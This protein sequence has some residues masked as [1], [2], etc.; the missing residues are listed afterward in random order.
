MSLKHHPDDESAILHEVQHVIT[1]EDEQHQKVNIKLVCKS[2]HIQEIVEYITNRISD[3]Y[4]LLLKV[5]E[6]TEENLIIKC[7]SIVNHGET[8]CNCP[9]LVLDYNLD[10]NYFELWK[11][12]G[13]SALFRSS[14]KP[15]RKYVHSKVSIMPEISGE[16]LGLSEFPSGQQ[17]TQCNVSKYDYSAVMKRLQ[18]G[19]Y[20]FHLLIKYCG[21]GPLEILNND[22]AMFLQ[23]HIQQQITSGHEKL[24]QSQ[25][26]KLWG[27][28]T[29]GEKTIRELQ[30]NKET[31]NLIFTN[32]KYK[33][34]KLLY[35][36]FKV[37][38]D[39]NGIIISTSFQFFEV[40]TLKLRAFDCTLQQDSTSQAVSDLNSFVQRRFQKSW[41]SYISEKKPIYASATIENVLIDVACK[42]V[43]KFANSEEQLSLFR[44]LS[45]KTVKFVVNLAWND[46]IIS[47]NKTSVLLFLTEYAKFYDFPKT[48]GLVFPGAESW[49]IPDTYTTNMLKMQEIPTAAAQPSKHLKLD[50][51]LYDTSFANETCSNSSS[52]DLSTQQPMQ[53]NSN[54]EFA[55]VFVLD[56][57]IASIPD[58][59][60]PLGENN[61]IL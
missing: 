6:S 24:D 19:S 1:V 23:K 58:T 4:R 37:I 5:N 38:A 2:Q 42:F 47:I 32:M 10:T 9:F 39:K 21:Y 20:D 15:L 8:K 17:N 18:L 57:Q 16:N 49:I 7:D 30:F 60:S 50:P 43:N 56:E 27:V 13:F 25:I 36:G 53:T 61:I 11:E 45:K 26:L 3:P 28:Q 51:D 46:L 22:Y 33:S 55:S 52:S 59:T 54:N 35:F 44:L 12:L 31:S 40:L 41:S 34:N 48:E 29:I 14:G